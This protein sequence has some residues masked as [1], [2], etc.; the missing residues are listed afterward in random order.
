[1]PLKGAV[2]ETTVVVAR[3]LLEACVFRNEFTAKQGRGRRYQGGRYRGKLELRLT[4][5]TRTCAGKKSQCTTSY[6]VCDSGRGSR[7]LWV[8]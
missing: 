3:T 7:M 1:M 8:K 6:I 5:F 2:A 4:V